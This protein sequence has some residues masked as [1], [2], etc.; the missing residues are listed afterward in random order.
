MLSLNILQ[1]N[2]FKFT[3][4]RMYEFQNFLNI[5]KPD[6]VSIQE[7]KLCEEEANFRLR[8]RG[9]DTFH[10]VRPYGSNFGGGVAI[11]IKSNIPH[12]QIQINDENLEL[13]GINIDIGKFNFDFFSLY[14]PPSQIVPYEFF[15]NYSR[16]K[17]KFILVGDLNSKTPCIGCKTQDRSGKKLEEILIDSDLIIFNNNMP[18]Y[19]KFN[20]NYEEI[21]DL[22]IGSSSIAN[23]ITDFRVLEDYSMMSDHFPV[24]VNLNL[25]AGDLQNL[26]NE[27]IEP[28]FNFQKA[29]WLLFHEVLLSKANSYSIEYI[30][31]L[32]AESLNTLVSTNIIEA[33]NRSIP[34]FCNRSNKSLPQEILCLIVERRKLRKEMKRNTLLKTQYNNLTAKIS[35]CIFLHK[36]GKWKQFLESLGDHPISARTFWSKINQ[37][38][39]VKQS[40]TIPNLRLEDREFKTESEKVDI[41]AEILSKTFSNNEIFDED[42]KK[43]IELENKKD[44]FA[45]EYEVFIVK[46]LYKIINNLKVNSSPG[47][48]CIQNIFFKFLPFEFIKKILLKLMNVSICQ[49]VPKSWKLALITMIPKKNAKS[50]NPNDYRPISLTSC[51]GKLAERLVK[52]RLNKFL[53]DNKLIIT[54]QSG[55][56]HQR[57]TSD[58]L[59][60][61]TQK[62]SENLEKGRKACSIFFD[63]SKAFD[64]VWHT[65]LIYK[66]K[67]LKVEAYIIRYIL[68]FLS[69]RS[70]K[71]KCNSTLSKESPIS[72]GVPQGSV[73]GPLLFLIYINDIPMAESKHISYSSLFADDLATLFTFKKDKKIIEKKIKGYIKSLV[74][75][76]LKWRLKMNASKCGYI[77]FS[78]VGTHEKITFNLSLPD[79]KIPYNHNPIFLGVTFDEHLT[80]QNHINSLKLRALKRLNI[81]KILCHKSWHLSKD[82][83]KGVYN[84]LVGSIF[85][86][87]FFM[88]ANVSATNLE[89]LQVIQNR[90]IRCIY[91]LE[92]NSSNYLLYPISGVLPVKKRLIVLGCRHLAK[93]MKCNSFIRLLVI[94]YLGSISS[95]RKK[96]NNWSEYSTPLCLILPYITLARAIHYLIF[97]LVFFVYNM[98]NN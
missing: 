5:F 23:K 73:L 44:N 33:A 29:N 59:L 91:K 37:L 74:E 64:K 70:F 65:G 89:K 8:F 41:F 55:F 50:K 36:N 71:V 54:Q 92:W 90:A 30:N 58:N 12:A 17:K 3:E 88:A 28:R 93:S 26:K 39:S 15:V 49:G 52:S 96:R 81:I 6:I 19:N 14:S 86:Y 25:S 4:A 34:K 66:L 53:E 76:L 11:I 72:C 79:G 85:T 21:L 46:D 43:N 80:F 84:A 95:I 10:K 57:G 56:R 2:C 22:V 24:S 16:S 9:Y 63:I 35:Q 67:K 1:W 47:G 87:S 62:I 48:D 78:N 82:T 60:F 75:W 51:L 68:D 32:D 42:H 7:L 31:S 45:G 69:N 61:F 98:S 18:T 77:V 27:L 97:G 40:A 83:L 94:E 20:S 38:R 13:L